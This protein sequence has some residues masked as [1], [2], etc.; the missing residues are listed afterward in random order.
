MDFIKKNYEKIILSV[1]LLGLVVVVG[2][3]P[4]VISNDQE[5][6]NNFKYQITHPKPLPLPPLDLANEDAALLRIKNAAPLDLSTSNRLFNPVTWLR[7]KNGNLIKVVS[8]KEVGGAAVVI[9]KITPLYYQIYLES[10]IT[11]E[12]PNARYVFVVQN[13][14]AGMPWQRSAQHQYASVGETNDVFALKNAAGPPDNP[15]RL[16]LVLVDTGLH[17]AVGPGNP[18][19]QVKGYMADLKYPPE[20]FTANNKRVGDQL[21]FAGDQYNIVA[22]D[23]N[24]VV[25]LAQ[26]NQKKY[27]LPYT[28]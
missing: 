6:T 17:V 25:L 7:D 1:V 27:V 2:F 18:Y 12:P 5:Q 15:T 22:I 21:N 4:V 20:N 24:D 26:S 9:T 16:D 8:G 3:L 10:V 28:P 14:A 23:Q 11:D 13:Q 19:R